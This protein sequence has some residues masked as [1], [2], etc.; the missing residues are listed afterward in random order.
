[1]AKSVIRFGLKVN[2]CRSKQ[3]IYLEVFL[4]VAH[5]LPE[6]AGGGNYDL[7][8]LGEALLLLGRSDATDNG[9]DANVSICGSS[10]EGV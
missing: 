4:A 2:K 3:R 9:G 1:M 7:G 6:A 10:A 5:V 8:T